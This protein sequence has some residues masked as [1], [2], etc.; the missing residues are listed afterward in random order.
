MLNIAHLALVA[1]LAGGVETGV[2]PRIDPETLGL[3][4]RFEREDAFCRS[5]KPAPRGEPSHC[6]ARDTLGLRLFVRGWC[7][8]QKA[9]APW[10]PCPWGAT[11]VKPEP[12]VSTQ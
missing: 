12:P 10:K 9:A 4:Q 2:P 1:M 6:E 5:G 11:T 7:Y 3:A 8:D